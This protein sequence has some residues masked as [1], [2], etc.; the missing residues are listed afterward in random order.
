MNH[1]LIT[2]HHIA[3]TFPN[4]G[5]SSSGDGMFLANYTY[6]FSDETEETYGVNLAQAAMNAFIVGRSVL[7]A[8]QG[9]GPSQES[10]NEDL[11][12]AARADIKLYVEAGLAAAAMHYLNDAIA[13]VSDADKIHH[14][15]EAL[16]FIYAMSFNSEGRLT[17][18]EA[19]NAL[20]AMGWSSSDSSLNGIYGINLWTV[21]DDQMTSAI[22]ILDQ[23]FPGFKDANF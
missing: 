8:G 1:L 14:L 12:V 15:S 18:E 6:D 11:F 23:S 22:N 2:M 7:K 16:A 17:A 10:V 19:H 20:I 3:A 9:F 5:N 21:T 4:D 13:D